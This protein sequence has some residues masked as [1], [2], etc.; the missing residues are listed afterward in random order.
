RYH[1]DTREAGVDTGRH[2]ASTLI[3][4]LIDEHAGGFA[5][6]EGLPGAKA[7]VLVP[8]QAKLLQVLDR[9]IEGATRK[10]VARDAH[11]LVAEREL[12]DRARLSLLSQH[13]RPRH[14]HILEEHLMDVALA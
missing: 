13:G 8:P 14:D 3:D 4:D 2:A 10:L 9:G 6:R 11:T 5:R 12:D 7:N 1:R